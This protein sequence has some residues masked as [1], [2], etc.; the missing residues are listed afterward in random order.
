M[1]ALYSEVLSTCKWADEDFVHGYHLLMGAIMA[2][3]APLSS[4]ALKSL[5]RQ[6]VELDIDGVLRPLSSLLT[7]LFDQDQ[8]IHI[9][10][11]S[12]RDFITC[13]AQSSLIH[14]RYYV[15]ETEHNQ[16]LAILCLH[17]LNEDLTSHTPGTGYLSASQS[18]TKGIPSIV[19]SDISE[20]VW[21]ACRFLMEHII[22]I[23]SDT[24]D[25]VLD[26]LRKFLAEKLTLWIEVLSTQYPFQSLS[27][28][29]AW[30]RVSAWINTFASY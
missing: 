11:L 12:F 24:S 14:Q 8:P 18:D 6:H 27:R 23:E 28:V 21:Y 19:P 9:L 25:T 26:S 22:E 30:L 7:G 29:R 3:K 15:S 1:D 13:R 16:R 2:A 10:H 4:I 20:V 17:V 5:H